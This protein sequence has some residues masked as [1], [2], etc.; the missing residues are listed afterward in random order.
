MSKIWRKGFIYFGVI[1]V[2]FIA[3]AP[4]YWIFVSSIQS[5]VNIRQGE[6]SP[7]PF[8]FTMENYVP[9]FTGYGVR[10]YEYILN[11]V[12]VAGAT[13]LLSILVAT[14]GAYGLSRY[15]FYGRET[16]SK[17]LLFIYVFPIILIV[18]PVN[19][20]LAKF[21]LS[22]ARLGL[23]LAHTALISPFCTWLLRS[24]FDS[25]PKS[26]EEAATLDSCNKFQSFIRIVFPLAAPRIAA[27]GIY[28][29]ITSWGEYPFA[30]IIISS[31]AKKTATLGIARYVGTDVD[32]QYV[33][34]G[35]ALV[36]LP[37]F[38]I[39]LPLAKYFLKGFLEGAI[40]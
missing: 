35:T 9:L 34:A 29:L 24:F 19:D 10:I 27:A 1:V 38:V 37:S 17:L 8:N 12:V 20:M 23:I 39:F 21:R 40:K 4:F 30:L 32:W 6:I 31:A 7:L 2:L 15:N 16:L 36:V 33:I 5:A 26:L 18:F 3:I 13:A 14:L 25:V 22:N 11:T 28:A